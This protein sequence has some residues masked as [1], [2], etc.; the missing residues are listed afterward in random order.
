[1]NLTKNTFISSDWHL[2][3]ANVIKWNNRPFNNLQEQSEY[4]RNA[5]L[6][7][8]PHST[9][10]LLGD[11]ILSKKFARPNLD[12]VFG[13]RS[14]ITY[15]FVLGNHDKRLSKYLEV[16]G[17][18]YH[19]VDAKYN[20]QKIVMSHYPMLE[21]D[22]AQHGSIHFYGHVHGMLTEGRHGILASGLKLDVTW[23]AHRKI[24][25]LETLVEMANGKP[26]WNPVH[27]KSNETNHSQLAIDIW[28]MEEL[29]RTHCDCLEGK[30][31]GLNRHD[32]S[33]NVSYIFHELQNIRSITIDPCLK[34]IMNNLT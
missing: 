17:R 5:I 26:I 2:D 28:R 34:S 31:P 14:D 11:T 3:H 18:T 15:I 29:I 20:G 19:Y 24:Q 33:C 7:L 4:F 1:M 27:S 21:W 13:C 9:L 8:P 23:D 16:H 30:D 22:G 12:Y 25:S 32:S 10:I 6:E